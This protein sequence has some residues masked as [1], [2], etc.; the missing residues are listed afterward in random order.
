MKYRNT[1]VSLVCALVLASANSAWA[2]SPTSVDSLVGTWVNVNPNTRGTVKIVVGKDSVGSLTINTFGACSPT[3]CNHGV[4]GASAYSSGVSSNVGIGFSA[5]YNS[6][7]K[8]TVVTGKLDYE[9]SDATFLAL[10][11][12]SKFAVGDTRKDYMS[13]ELFRKQ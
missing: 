9:Y 12:H 8:T 1:A 10:G 11:S 13:T 6:G 5:Q 3:P 7:F 2:V 4:I